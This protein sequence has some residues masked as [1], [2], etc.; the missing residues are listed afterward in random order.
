MSLF[1]LSISYSS[2]YKST[3]PGPEPS[4]NCVHTH[5]KQ[6]KTFRYTQS[7]SI[8][9]RLTQITNNKSCLLAIRLPLHQAAR[10]QTPAQEVLPSNSFSRSPSCRSSIVY[11]TFIL[12]HALPG[13]SSILSHPEHH[14]MLWTHFRRC[15]SR[16]GPWE[17]CCAPVQPS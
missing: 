6:V 17:R 8:S 16:L 13:L 1:F 2:F 15:S 10:A 14:R 11:T 9:S 4:G 7:I 12:Y 5:F 3:V